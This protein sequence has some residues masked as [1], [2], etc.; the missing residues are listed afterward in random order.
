MKT[1]EQKAEE[2]AEIRAALYRKQ[3]RDYVR[4]QLEACSYNKRF[5]L[6]PAMII[7]PFC[8]EKL[9]N[10]ECKYCLAKFKV[11][12]KVSEEGMRSAAEEGYFLVPKV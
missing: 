6:R 11:V 7:C 5:S 4:A 12:E 3:K 2:A 10:L 1:E 8:R 9:K